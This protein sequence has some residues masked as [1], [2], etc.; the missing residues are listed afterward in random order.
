MTDQFTELDARAARLREVLEAKPSL[1]DVL[2]RA[3]SEPPSPVV[4]EDTKLLGNVRGGLLF[5]AGALGL[6]I[7][8]H[9]VESRPMWPLITPVTLVSL[10]LVQAIA[11][12][13]MMRGRMVK[14]ETE[15]EQLREER[16][17]ARA[18]K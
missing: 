17:S 8:I 14:L 7:A 9:F 11:A 13:K 15:M 6:C 5:S 16:R 1:S 3:P 4:I 10:A 18:V 12:M 2:D